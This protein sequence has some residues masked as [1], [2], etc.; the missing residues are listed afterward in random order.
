MTV[1]S[2]VK[3]NGGRSRKEGG[4]PT[5]QQD[6]HL[7]CNAHAIKMMC[8][9]VLWRASSQK[10]WQ[11][12]L[13]MPINQE[14]Q[15]VGCYTKDFS[16]RH[17]FPLFPSIQPQALVFPTTRPMIEFCRAG[18][19]ER[20]SPWVRICQPGRPVCSHAAQSTRVARYLRGARLSVAVSSRRVVSCV[21]T[22]FLVRINPREGLGAE[23][24][25]S[26]EHLL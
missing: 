6:Q 5:Q 4:K 14:I 18:R 26:H 11:L 19:P 16:Q 22:F 23:M 7:Q 17:D 13:K 15:R 24:R 10:C 12:A 2:R 21:K 9:V 25:G 20:G 1:L 3:R 8:T